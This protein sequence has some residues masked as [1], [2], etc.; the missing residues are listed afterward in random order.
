SPNQITSLIGHFLGRY[1]RE[2]DVVTAQ[3]PIVTLWTGQ[4]PRF[5]AP[6]FADRVGQIE[7]TRMY[8]TGTWLQR[9]VY[10]LNYEYILRQTGITSGSGL[11]RVVHEG[12]RALSEFGMMD[13]RKIKQ[14]EVASRFRQDVTYDLYRIPRL[15]TATLD[16]RLVNKLK[17]SAAVSGATI[18]AADQVGRKQSLSAP[19]GKV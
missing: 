19:D 12:P 17:P 14:A 9:D 13:S 10:P 8:R 15:G 7:A 5:V 6:L 4:S 1:H 11:I 3:I 2:N 16:V 18:E